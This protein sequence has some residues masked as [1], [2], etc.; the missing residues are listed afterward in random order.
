MDIQHGTPPSR[1]FAADSVGPKV[2]SWL[3]G[4]GIF[5]STPLDLDFAM[6]LAFPSAYDIDNAELVVPDE[7]AFK[8]VLGKSHDTATDQYS[9]GQLLYF[10]AYNR[11]FKNGSKPVWHIR[12]M[13]QLDDFMIENLAPA[14]LDRLVKHALDALKAVPE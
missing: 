13:S 8:S 12:A 10:D 6:M 9:D 3:E 5:F 2:I 4:K 1:L 14:S 7:A 11:R